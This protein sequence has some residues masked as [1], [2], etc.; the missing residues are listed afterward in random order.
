MPNQIKKQSP[1]SQDSGTRVSAER[2]RMQLFT[3]KERDDGAYSDPI[4]QRVQRSV[5]SDVYP[6]PT[7]SG[8]CSG[9]RS[10]WE[11]VMVVE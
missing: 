1:T 3:E 11:K 9:F 8:T 2:V 6:I 7:P 5:L 4:R 10:A